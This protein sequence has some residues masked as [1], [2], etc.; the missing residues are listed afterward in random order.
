MRQSRITAALAATA[1]GLWLAPGVAV[2]QDSDGS[3][4]NATEESAGQESAG[5]TGSGQSQSGGTL[6]RGDQM[7]FDAR[8][9]RGERASGA[10][11]LFQR[12]PRE[13]PSMV[14]RQRS[15]LDE[16]VETTLGADWA[17][18]FET[19]RAKH[20]GSESTDGEADQRQ[21]QSSDETTSDE[22]DDTSSDEDG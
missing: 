9:I 16:S 7:E 14:E 3:E 20:V 17:D 12:T 15:Y 2:G 21:T 4:G 18:N 6:Q 22:S 8:L 1:L 10:V 19:A 11:F 13:L 5:A